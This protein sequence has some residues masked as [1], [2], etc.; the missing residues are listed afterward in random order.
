MRYVRFIGVDGAINYG[1]YLDN[2]VQKIN[3]DLFVEYS[4]TEEFLDFSDVTL[5][6][7]VAPSKVIALGYNYKDLIGERE[8]YD[9][10]VMFL[11]LPTSII[12]PEEDILL[13]ETDKSVWAEVEIAIV[14]GKQAS[15]VSVEDA[16]DYI[17]GYTIA[18]DVTMDNVLGRDHHLARS[19]AWDSACPIGPWIETELDTSSLILQNHINGNKYQDS[20]SSQ[21]ILN[22]A[23]VVSFVSNFITL[24]PGDVILTG[25]PAGA[26]DSLLT[27]GDYVTVSVEGIGELKNTIARRE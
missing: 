8:K 21:R 9:E 22:D 15:C 23:E 16:K 25:T 14:I 20:C 24:M 26:E 7:P 18:N 17:F 12:G 1:K 4:L 27:H 13:I 3:G 11:I 2:K 19:K 5:K 6:S 10:P